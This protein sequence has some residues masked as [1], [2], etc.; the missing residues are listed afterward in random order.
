LIWWQ[1]FDNT[2]PIIENKDDNLSSLQNYFGDIK[3]C[4]PFVIKILNRE[5]NSCIR[6][7]WFR[8]CS[9]CILDPFKDTN[10]IINPT[11][12]IVVEWCYNTVKN[13]MNESNLRL[14]LNHETVKAKEEDKSVKTLDECINLFLEKEYLEGNDQQIYC[15]CCK[16]L[17][18]FYKKYDFDRVPPYL[19]LTLKRFK[20]AKLYKKKIDNLIDFPLHDLLVKGNKYDLYGIINHFGDLQSGHYTSIV[21]TNNKWVRC[22]D[23]RCTEI[24]ESSIISPQAY[25]LVY[26]LKDEINTDYFRMMTYIL[27]SLDLKIENELKKNEVVAVNFSDK[28]YLPGEPVMTLYGRGYVVKEIIRDGEKLVS[29]KFKFGTGV[30]KYYNI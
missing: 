13:E 29:V 14:V 20:F 5:N 17:K 11:Q 28:I 3:Y 16:S 27:N 10:V 23:S 2:S 12:V 7:P 15:S 4:A 18:N 9:G 1:N 30:L 22:D 19:I 8:Y 25:I 26:K 6:C 24:H 21:R